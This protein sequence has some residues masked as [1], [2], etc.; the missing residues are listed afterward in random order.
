MI[1]EGVEALQDLQELVKKKKKK[2]RGLDLGES[3]I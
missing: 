3:I 1:W 2:S